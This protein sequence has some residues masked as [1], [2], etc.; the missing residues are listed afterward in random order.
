MRRRVLT[1]AVGVVTA[2]SGLTLTATPAHAD[3]TY[4]GCLADGKYMF[5]QY[6]ASHDQHVYSC[7]WSPYYRYWKYVSTCAEGTHPV[8]V[9]T[10]TSEPGLYIAQTTCVTN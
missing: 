6:P 7:E 9:L 8:A 1:L 4:W 3:Q 2:L 10:E 5:G